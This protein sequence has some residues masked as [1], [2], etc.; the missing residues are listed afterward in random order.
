MTSYVEYQEYKEIVERLKKRIEE[1]R[2]PKTDNDHFWFSADG[3][4]GYD[5]KAFADELQKIL[6]G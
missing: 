5:D 2:N 1:S 4:A 6:E 3:G